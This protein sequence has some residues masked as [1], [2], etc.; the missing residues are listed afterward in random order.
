MKFKVTESEVKKA[1]KEGLIITCDTREKGNKSTIA[2][3]DQNKVKYKSLKL[4]NGDYSCILKAGSLKGIDRDIDF[5]KKIVIEK[6]AGLDEICGNFSKND[7]PRLKSEFSHLAMNGT[8][9]FVFVEDNLFDKHLRNGNY[10][11]LYDS[12]TLYARLKGFEA[13]YNTIVRPVD[14]EYIGGEIFNTLYY[15]ARHYLLREFKVIE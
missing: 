7:T 14:K 11:S 12:K 9:V 10:R 15:Y 4:D 8:R 1:L 13:E 3:F 6:K 2:W 5:S